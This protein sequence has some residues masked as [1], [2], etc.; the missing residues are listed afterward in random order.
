[1]KRLIVPCLLLLIFLLFSACDGDSAASTEPVSEPVSGPETTEAPDSTA[2]PIDTDALAEYV[3]VWDYPAENRLLCIE[4]D[5][6]WTMEDFWHGTPLAGQLE[7]TGDGI[8]CRAADGTVLFLRANGSAGLTDGDGSN[9][10]RLTE[11]EAAVRRRTAYAVSFALSVVRQSPHAGG[12]EGNPYQAPKARFEALSKAQKA[13][14]DELLSRAA[15]MEALV[16][17]ADEAEDAAK[18]GAALLEDYPEYRL[19]LQ[20][21]PERDGSLK[22]V[23]R[24]PGSVQQPDGSEPDQIRAELAIFDAVCDEVISHLPAD[25]S[26][27]DQ[28]RYLAVYLCAKTE[29]DTLGLGGTD[30]AS[31]YGAIEGGWATAEGYA[32]GFEYL[33][34]RANLA[35]EIVTGALVAADGTQTPHVWNRVEIGSRTRIIDLARID[36]GA[37]TPFDEDWYEAFWVPEEEAADYQS[38]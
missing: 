27:Y 4:A 7:L 22:T 30:A 36:D 35:C 23:Y 34:R 11:T 31:A 2:S 32:R 8:S 29:P 6:S 9:L 18:A 19:Y 24:L 38:N 5:G 25:A 33:C 26:V 21:V 10:A 17:P 13:I 14:Y 16:W 3:G 20:L 12:S 1:M 28:Y 15:L 37:F